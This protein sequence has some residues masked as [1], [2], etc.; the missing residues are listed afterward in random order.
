MER[1]RCVEPP[2]A[3]EVTAAFEKLPLPGM[4]QLAL[5]RVLAHNPRVLRRIAGAGL[6]D[7]GSIPVRLRELAI[8]RT[9]A[10]CGAEYEW[11]VHVKAFGVAA[12]LDESAA[13][14]TWIDGSSGECWNP[15]ERLVLRL[16]EELHATNGID[17]ALWSEL[18]AHFEPTQLVE[19][20]VLA[21][22]YHAIS[23]VVNGCRVPLEAWATRAP[24]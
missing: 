16:C 19:L 10:L 15:E 1:L 4:A 22:L 11:G 2:Y 17:D 23:Y 6:L 24:S 3:E 13:R 18:A 8:L 21:G 7:V 14:S 20:I 9:C 5:F 12:G